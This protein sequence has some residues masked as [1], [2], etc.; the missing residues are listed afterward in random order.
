MHSRIGLLVI[1]ALIVLAIFWIGKHTDFGKDANFFVPTDPPVG[2][3]DYLSEN[4]DCV[5]PR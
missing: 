1:L 5:T 3:E 2:P 4:P